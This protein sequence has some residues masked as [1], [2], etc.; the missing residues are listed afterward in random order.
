MSTQLRGNVILANP[1]TGNFVVKTNLDCTMC[2]Y[3]GGADSEIGDILSGA[4]HEL[5][6]VKLR[7]EAKGQDVEVFIDDIY[8]SKQVAAEWLAKR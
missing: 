5:G 4:L 6:V 1:R 8:A 2:E 3:L 7:N